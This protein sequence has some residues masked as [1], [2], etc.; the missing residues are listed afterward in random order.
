[1]E[2]KRVT[3]VQSYD[4]FITVFHGDGWTDFD[5]VYYEGVSEGDIRKELDN[6]FDSDS[7]GL[8]IEEMCNLGWIY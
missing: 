5:S 8:I 3:S 7:V 6:E 4:D 2:K 1:M